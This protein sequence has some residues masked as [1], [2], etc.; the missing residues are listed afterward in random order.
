MR[1]VDPNIPSMATDLT[2]VTASGQS[3]EIV[4]QVK[5]P[6]KVEALVVMG[7]SGEQKTSKPAHI[8]SRP[9]SKN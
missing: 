3:L 5:V 1:R 7:I 9:Y 2:C 6:L 8:G 4:G